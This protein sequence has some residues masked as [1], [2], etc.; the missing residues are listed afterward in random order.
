MMTRARPHMST[1][2]LPHDTGN[3]PSTLLGGSLT[4][5]AQAASVLDRVSLETRDAVRIGLLLVGVTVGCVLITL[6]LK[7]EHVHEL[8]H[9]HVHRLLQDAELGETIQSLRVLLS[10]ERARLYNIEPD[11]SHKL[12]L[13][14]R[15]IS[16]VYNVIAS[17]EH[18]KGCGR[19]W[20]S[21]QLTRSTQAVQVYECVVSC[22][23]RCRR[24]ARCCWRWLLTTESTRGCA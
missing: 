5:L 7:A 17:L 3:A 2:R 23:E 19:W 4:C 9:G 12:Q 8:K 22:C 6:L 15:R 18:A 1:R 14:S 16:S 24:S 20:C 11:D 13:Q 10:K 21:K